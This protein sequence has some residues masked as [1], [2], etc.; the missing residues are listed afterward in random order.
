MNLS[1]VH[2]SSSN[3]LSILLLFPFFTKNPCFK[4]QNLE[5]RS[6]VL[7]A[8]RQRKDQYH[9][10]MPQLWH[11]FSFAFSILSTPQNSLLEIATS[12]E[13]FPHLSYFLLHCI[14]KAAVPFTHTLKTLPDI[15]SEL[16]F[17]VARLQ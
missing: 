15:F 2:Q 3:N 16:V 13:R 10:I 9:L 6:R 8:E 11:L 17:C 7:G 1:Q 5:R 12:F 4:C 14:H